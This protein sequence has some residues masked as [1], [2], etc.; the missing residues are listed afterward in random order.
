MAD[1]DYIDRLKSNLGKDRFMSVHGELKN[2]D[3]VG[4]EQMVDIANRFN[5]PLAPS[6]SRKK[7]LE[8]IYSRHRKLVDL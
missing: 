2:D 3:N 7:A 8:T 6:S 4:R 5:G 1:D